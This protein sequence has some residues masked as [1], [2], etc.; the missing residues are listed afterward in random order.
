MNKTVT[1]RSIIKLR[2]LDYSMSVWLDERS[3]V[4]FILRDTSWDK[5][6]GGC[7]MYRF[8]TLLESL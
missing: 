4:L 2:D 8:I 6:S 3:Q 7:P 5:Q 1:D